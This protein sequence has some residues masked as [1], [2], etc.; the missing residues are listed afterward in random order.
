MG[1]SYMQNKPKIVV[2]AGP[3]GSGKSTITGT[4]I[5]CGKY[6]NADVIQ[7]ERSIS[8][9]DAALEATSL[10]EIELS[11]KRDFTFE[12]VLSTERNLN[13]LQRAKETGILSE[14]ITY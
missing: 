8:V 5:I 4:T 7:K 13:L 12:T 1:E 11:N 6:I 3:N 14:D 2:F 10:R 9:W